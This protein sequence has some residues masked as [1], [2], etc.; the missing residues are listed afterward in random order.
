MEE[1]MKRLNP[2][3]IKDETD[4]FMVFSDYGK[5]Y[6]YVLKKAKE[7]FPRGFIDVPLL[8]SYLTHCSI[9]EAEKLSSK[10]TL[11]SLENDIYLAPWSENPKVEIDMLMRSLHTLSDTQFSVDYFNWAWYEFTK[12]T[13]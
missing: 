7:M 9:G 3:G 1:I 2:F 11:I 8:I 6:L 4:E 12:E 13:P 5:C 10:F